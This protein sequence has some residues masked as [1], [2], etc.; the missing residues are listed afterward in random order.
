VANS[1]RTTKPR[2]EVIKSS[3][4]DQSSTSNSDAGGAL[5][6]ALL[7]PAVARALV[8]R[9]AQLGRIP[10]ESGA[11]DIAVELGR[12]RSESPRLWQEHRCILEYLV[13]ESENHGLSLTV[14]G[15]KIMTA[16]NMRFTKG[17]IEY[18]KRALA[19]LRDTVVEA[20]GP[21]NQSGASG[22]QELRFLESFVWGENGGVS[23]VLSP[24]AVATYRPGASKALREQ[25]IKE[26]SD[27]WWRS[28]TAGFVADGSSATVSRADLLA[29]AGTV[30][31]EAKNVWAYM[32]EVPSE[33]NG[34]EDAFWRDKAYRAA[35]SA[36]YWAKLSF[37]HSEVNDGKAEK[38]LIEN[39][40]RMTDYLRSGGFVQDGSNVVAWRIVGDD[41]MEIVPFE[42]SGLPRQGG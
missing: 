13:N 11:W 40:V 10:D 9:S 15:P 14:P 7:H 22:C 1:R 42:K 3:P 4:T 33:Q 5:T 12:A 31:E 2:R 8:F 6:Q 37:S 29:L 34:L 39:K 36:A 28:W 17:S 16:M 19:R 41:R 27:T 23:V 30:G 38:R 35:E 18:G 26:D 20:W 24:S 25:L 21:G 32:T